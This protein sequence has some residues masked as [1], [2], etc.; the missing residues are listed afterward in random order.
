MNPPL[1]DAAVSQIILHRGAKFSLS[2]SCELVILF[3]RF[4]FTE[5]LPVGSGEEYLFI[6]GQW[7]TDAWVLRME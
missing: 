4:L 7:N 3:A 5:S 1:L 6:H 2:I